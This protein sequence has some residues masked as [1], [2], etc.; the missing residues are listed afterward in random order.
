[1]KQWRKQIRRARSI[2]VVSILGFVSHLKGEDNLA[3]SR[4]LDLSFDARQV[5][6]S[7]S[8]M[9]VSYAEALQNAKES[10]VSVHSARILRV[11][12]QRG[13][14]PR[15][16]LLRRYF[17]LPLPQRQAT[18]IE[19]RRL[20]QGVGS[21]V[22]I[23][24][25]GY[26]L[27]NNHVITTE[28][29]SSADEV[30]VELNDG[31][32]LVAEIIGRDPLTDLALLKIDAQSLVAVELADSDD[33]QVGDVVFAVGNPMGIGL[34]ITQGIVSATKRDDLSILGEGSLESFIQTDAPI[35]PGNSGGAL[36]DTFGRLVGINTAILSRSGGSVGIGFAVP[37][38]IAR[39]IVQQLVQ[40]GRVVRSVFGAELTEMTDELRDAFSIPEA[41]V[42]LLVE[43]ADPGLPASLGGLREG[44]V[45]VNLDNKSL[46]HKID[47]E[48]AM[49]GREPGSLVDLCI[50]RDGERQK[51][52][53]RLGDPADPYGG[54]VDVGDLF[55]GVTVTRFAGT[56]SRRFR[57]E[58]HVQGLR[59]ESV[60]PSND[61]EVREGMIILEIN[62][63]VPRSI[64]HGRSLFRKNGLNKIFVLYR[65][66]TGYLPIHYESTLN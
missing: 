20:A 47:F 57:F 49:I 22:I 9:R 59:V 7:D 44:D 17:G 37:T 51:I 50:F 43:V 11:M 6:R 60:D 61:Q 58:T 65:G 3:N 32:E 62:G 5:N 53:V 29:G 41:H 39:P 48:L 52:A 4:A 8:R 24:S 55:P 23:D 56:V 38:S 12:R 35:N 46:I 14:D 18:G 27:T 1:M 54:G 25:D 66:Q 19:T 31:E 2:A 40:R 15:D 42:G 33:L 36:L 21:G 10:V 45:I 16:E 28:D 30:L 63:T 64:E 13:I 34:T 26:I